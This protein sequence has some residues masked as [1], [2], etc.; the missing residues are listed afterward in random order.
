M[1]NDY[2]ILGIARGAGKDEIKRAYFQLVRQF[3]PEKD[4]ERF[5]EIRGAYER[6]LQES[7]E[8]KIAG[9]EMEIPDDPL[10]NSMFDR[11]VALVQQ[12][13]YK[14]AA[15]LARDAVSYFGECEAFLYELAYTQRLSGHS[16]N[17][18]KNYVKLTEKYPD[19]KI[20]KK[21]LALAY[22]DRGFVKKAY[23][24]FEDAY[25]AG[26]R[27]EDFIL[28]FSL[29]CRDRDEYDRGIAILSRMVE[30]YDSMAKGRELDYLEACMGFFMMDFYSGCRYFDS[31]VKIYAGFLKAAG[32]ILKKY[33]EAVFSN[34]CF[35][36]MYIP[37][38]RNIPQVKEVLEVVDGIFPKTKFKEEWDSI[39]NRL[40]SAEIDFDSRI[41]EEIEW[42]FAAF[43]EAYDI[44]DDYVIRFMQTDC[45]LVIIERLPDIKPQFDIVKN[46][47]PE[48]YKRMEDF[49]VQ[50]DIEDIS[51]MKQKLLKEY[52]KMEKNVTGGHY[53][54]L[55]PQNRPETGKMQW[56]SSEEGS[57]VRPGKKIGR[58][59]PCPCGS[60][61]KYK[62]C[63]GRNKS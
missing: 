46:E 25:K 11:I 2:E 41:G 59:D 63:C 35:L 27:D 20:Y 17:A 18:I 57:F 54:E 47:Y 6:L 29:C 62:Q 58:N 42:C 26:V 3:S 10:A 1:Q 7:S 12:G 60:G 51:Y 14:K 39:T 24:A 61:K 9:L 34:V 40:Y 8:E 22:F 44:Y 53:Y 16:G 4:P 43:I 45:K 13:E 36:V 37:D 5:Q 30:D 56:N 49:I 23:A 15:G 31:N 28:E 55:Y 19:N 48:L 38:S 32:R 21:G 52:D 33:K 50:L